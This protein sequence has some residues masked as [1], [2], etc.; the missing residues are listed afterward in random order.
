MVL[1]KEKLTF[2]KIIGA[3]LSVIGV[4]TCVQ[5]WLSDRDSEP[6]GVVTKSHQNHRRIRNSKNFLR[7]LFHYLH[8]YEHIQESWV[9]SGLNE[10]NVTTVEPILPEDDGLDE[11]FG[12][13]MAATAGV[14]ISFANILIKFRLQ[15]VSPS[16]LN[17][18]AGALGTIIPLIISLSTENIVFPTEDWDI[19]YLCLQVN[20]FFIVYQKVS[21]CEF[22]K[23][24][25]NFEEKV[26]KPQYYFEKTIKS[27]S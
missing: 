12:Y 17:L 19:V 8:N 14:V 5:P 20:I 3:S 16:H 1:L 4:I 18:Y 23:Y 15:E 21:I 27:H 7:P 25:R 11:V 6:E 2:P 22:L 26:I 10:T 13:I 9:T 24:L